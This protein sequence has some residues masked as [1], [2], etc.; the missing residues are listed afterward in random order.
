MDMKEASAMTE[1]SG[2]RN[3]QD[4]NE[5][6]MRAGDRSSRLRGMSRSAGPS[7]CAM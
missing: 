5:H 4:G 6:P 1:A 2:L 7:G 3:E